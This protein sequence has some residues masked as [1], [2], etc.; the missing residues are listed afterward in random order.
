MTPIVE[1]QSSPLHFN[2]KVMVVVVFVAME[3]ILAEHQIIEISSRVSIM[4][5]LAILSRIVGISINL[6][7]CP[8]QEQARSFPH[9]GCFGS[10]PNAHIVAFT[11]SCIVH[12]LSTSFNNLILVF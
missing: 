12:T 2:K 3:T 10:C 4:V 8:P 9:G 6:N 5:A 11:S 7:H 1:N